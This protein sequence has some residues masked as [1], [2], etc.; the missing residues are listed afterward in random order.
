MTPAQLKKGQEVYQKIE[1][2]ER[3]LLYFQK[4]DEIKD[5]KE[6]AEKIV[7]FISGCNNLCS[8]T[9]IRSLVYSIMASAATSVLRDV[10]EKLHNELDEI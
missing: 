1:D 7:D 9:K 3:V 4:V 2:L 10:L 5:G 8:D 6:K